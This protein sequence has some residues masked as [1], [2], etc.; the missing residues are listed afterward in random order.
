LT[1]GDAIVIELKNVS[2]RFRNGQVEVRALQNVN[3][4]IRKAEFVAVMGAS[5]SGKSTLLNILGCLDKPTEGEY[6]L[7][8]VH[9]NTLSKN[10]LSDIRNQKIGF[11]FQNYNLLARTSAIENVELP[12]VY[13]R[14]RNFPDIRETARKALQQ[15]GL[16]DRA[17]HRPNEMSGGQQQRVAIARALVNDPAVILS[18]EATGNLDSRS[19]IDIADLFVQL[20]NQGKTILMITHEPDIARFAKRMIVFRDG[21]IISDEVLK[22]R[23]SKEKALADLEKFSVKE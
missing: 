12:L 8:G 9:I 18:D 3:L 5:G 6:F 17:S 10:E 21:K 22:D 7:D 2:R 20:N 11:I 14:S 13:S 4:S 23:N 1:S 15:V 16:E 19:S